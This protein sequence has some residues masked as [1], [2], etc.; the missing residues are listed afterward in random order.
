MKTLKN[1]RIQNSIAVTVI[2]SLLFLTSCKKEDLVT[3]TSGNAT[4]TDGVKQA[5]QAKSN[6]IHPPAEFRAELPKA[7][8]STVMIKIDHIAAR[9]HAPDYS[10]SIKFDG[11]II[12]EGRRNVA[13]VGTKEWQLASDKFMNVKQLFDH[14]GFN[15]IE[16]NLSE[17]ADVPMVYTT[18]CAS[19]AQRATTLFDY[20]DGYP[21]GLISLRQKAESILD[22]WEYINYFEP[23]KATGTLVK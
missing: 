4:A 11:T 14:S 3:T 1:L 5:P 19:P 17:L 2:V 12:F 9:T 16:D 20:N 22:L 8:Q 23:M 21:E 18:W 6:Q 13:Y 15:S 7:G 10:V